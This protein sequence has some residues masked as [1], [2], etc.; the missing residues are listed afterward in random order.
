MTICTY[1]GEKTR[2]EP[3]R[4]HVTPKSWRGPRDPWDDDRIVWACEPCNRSKGVNSPATWFFVLIRKNGA[5]LGRGESLAD[6]QL[7]LIWAGWE[8]EIRFLL[9][10]VS[11]M[12]P[13]LEEVPS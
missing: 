6:R 8:P 13:A 12:V 7:D 1:C 5:V 11:A 9:G 10:V 3:Q 2:G 4:D